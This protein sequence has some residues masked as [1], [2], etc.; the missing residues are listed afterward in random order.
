MGGHLFQF[1]ARTLVPVWLRGSDRPFAT[2]SAACVKVV[3]HR[4]KPG[5]DTILGGAV[6]GEV[7]S[8]RAWPGDD[9]MLGGAV[10]GTMGPRA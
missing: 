8:H 1:G 7:V 2:R 10:C 5:D 4:A 6:C 9:T 3:G